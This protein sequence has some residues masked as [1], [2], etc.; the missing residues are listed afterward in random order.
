MYRERLA[1]LAAAFRRKFVGSDGRLAIETQTACVLAL[2]TG[3]MPREHVAAV[4]SQLVDRIARNDFRMATGFLGTKSILPVLSA[5][6]HHDLACRLFQSRKFPS[7]GYEVEQGANS[8]WERWDS[9]T[10]EHGFDGATGKNNAAM[11]SFSHYAFGAVMEWAFRE[12]AGIDM[13]EPGYGRIRIRPRIP[14]AQSNPDGE[15]LDWVEAEYASLRGL[16][17]SHWRRNGETVEMR[18]TIPPNTTAEVHVPCR[19][20]SDVLVDGKPLN[21]GVEDVRVLADSSPVTVLEVGSGD[22]LFRGALGARE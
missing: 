21:A 17:R 7:W 19:Q 1:D 8:V 22:Y 11:N 4:V 14:S 18:V 20:V 16:I 3:V 13:L 6:G 12:L 15:P 9:F 2:D 10:K 5:H